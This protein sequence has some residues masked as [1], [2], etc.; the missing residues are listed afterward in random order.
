MLQLGASHTELNSISRVVLQSI[1]CCSFRERKTYSCDVLDVGV[2]LFAVTIIS[3]VD[4]WEGSF[5]M[6]DFTL[7]WT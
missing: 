1:F 3:I 6:A 4:T 2:V 5:F 7:L